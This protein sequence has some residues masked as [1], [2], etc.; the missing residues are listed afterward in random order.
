MKLNNL[1]RLVFALVALVLFS[2]LPLVASAEIIDDM[3]V[4]TDANGEVDLV[5]KFAFQIQFLR[6]FP[7]GKTPYSAIYFNV[8]GGVPPDQWQN[9]ESHRTPPSDVFQDVT[10]STQDKATGPTVQVKLTKPADINVTL[11][12]NG[13]SLIIHIKPD[14]SA[15]PVPGVSSAPSGEI[16]APKV[17]L[18]AATL[19]AIHI[20]YGGKD[21]LPVYPD[22]DQPTEQ[23]PVAESA[24]PTLSEQIIKA[25]NQASPLMI[26]GGNALVAGQAFAAV[27]SFN[28]VLK[29]PPNKYT[30]DAQLWV[31]IAKEK[32]G[33]L[34]RAILEYDSFL[35]LYPNGRWAKWVKDRLELLKTSQPKL[36]VVAP[37]V[38]ITLPKIKNTEFQFTEF[39]SLS[40]EAYL[41]ANQTNTSAVGGTSQAPTSISTTTQKS[42][43]TNV[44]VTARSYNNEY[45]NRLVLQEFYSANY[46]PGQ[47]NSSRLGSAFYEMKDRV[48]SYSVKIGRQS[49][50]GGGVMGRFDGVAA[51]YGINSE[52]KANIVAGQLSDSSLDSQ[53]IF[54]GASLDFGLKNQLGGSVYYIN[55]T[56]S[57]FTDRR[58]IGG[59]LR[60]FEPAF[61][62]MSMFDYDTQ[63]RELN[64]LTVQG[65]LSGGGKGNDY[66][67]L[68]DRRRSPILDL[69]N[70][71]NGTTATLNSLLQNGWDTEGLILLADQ[72]TTVTNSA[73]MGMVNHLNEKWNTGTDVSYSITDAL[74]ASGTDPAL[75]GGGTPVEG[76]VPASPSSGPLWSVSQR[77]TGMGVFRARDVTNFGV[78]YSKSETSSSESLQ[79]SNHTDV[80]D[81]WSL[82][83]SLTLGFQKDNV[84]GKSNNFSPSERVSYRLKSNLT[85]DGQLGLSWSKTSSEALQSSSNSFQDFLSFGFRFDF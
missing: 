31:G 7:Q 10:V 82:D 15:L 75:I 65:T 1:F 2:S 23:P 71:I 67:F 24:I 55:Q 54:M 41:G 61:N 59:N 36:F 45:D 66:N 21:G 22:I 56:V 51:G 70:A 58:A 37:P 32:T 5:V 81:Q 84:G 78:T 19:K 69:R 38:V 27:E 8:L 74:A 73:S 11:G 52:Y 62:I 80:G 34:P 25:N 39:G 17:V 26:E 35:K 68:V 83:S 48:D 63:F 64:I 28:N 47:A 46:L 85:L 40:M 60:Y 16:T 44:N 12:K 3:T 50:M 33:Q 6:N 49:G 9:Y 29:L 42:V 18:P 53:P 4:H 43:I 79:C 76:F 14:A 13:Q 57:G 20:P 30:E 72:R 77:L